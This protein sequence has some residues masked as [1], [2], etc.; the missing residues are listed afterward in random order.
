MNTKQ[1]IGLVG[2]CMLFMGVFAPIVTLPF[3]GSMN[4]FQNGKGDGVFLIGFAIIAL[5]GSFTKKNGLL[6]VSGIGSLGVLAF[7]YINFQTKMSDAKMSMDREMEGNPFGGLAKLAMQSVQIQW[8]W[9]LLILGAV[10]VIGAA[11]LKEEQSQSSKQK[12]YGED[13]VPRPKPANSY[14]GIPQKKNAIQ[15]LRALVNDGT[16]TEE[17]FQRM[18]KNHE[19]NEEG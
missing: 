1:I 7:T 19:N 17:Q 9:A 8:G 14:G 2:A 5:L 18:K 6:W 4:Y 3:V 13:P 16:I 11:I 12:L 15:Q 10:F